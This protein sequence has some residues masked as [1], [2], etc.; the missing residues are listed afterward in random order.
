MPRLTETEKLARDICWAEFTRRPDKTKA[1]YWYALAPNAKADY[2]GDAEWL[3]WIVPRL[4]RLK[5]LALT[6]P[7]KD[8]RRS[9]R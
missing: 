4:K 1:V 3:E 9:R 5:L 7:K 8:G 6:E 2:I